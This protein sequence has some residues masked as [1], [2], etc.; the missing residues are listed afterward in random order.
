MT[1]FK[2]VIVPIVTPFSDQDEV[3]VAALHENVEFLISEG[4]HAIL[5]A[6]STGEAMCLTPS[7]Y[8][9]VLE[10]TIKQVRGR[11]PVIAGCSANAT[12]VVVANCELAKELGADGY[13]VTHPYYSRPDPHEL[14]EHY[15]TV[16]AAL[17]RPLIVYNNPYTTGVDASAEQLA[18]FG[19][20]P[21]IEYVKESSGDAT[22]VARLLLLTD[23][24]LHV[25]C[26]TDNLALESFV[27]GATG[28]VAGVAN[29]LPRA[30]VRLYQL[31][32]E[33]NRYVEARDL[34]ASMF[35]F[36]DLAESTGKFVQVNK[37]A[38]E[39]AGHRAGRPR[40]PLLPLDHNTMDALRAAFI[41]ASTAAAG[42]QE[43]GALGS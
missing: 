13:M 1:V 20:L 16:A 35:A 21:H 40:Q 29:S 9:L 24:R 34:Y 19:T 30:C 10:E 36:L 26:G 8:R 28:W 7:E 6:G 39:L 31:A 37:A 42:K 5:P 15:R 41:R 18:A 2:G 3:D 23:G 25:L 38:V 11:V 14:L 33:E 32:A 43:A 22:R 27:A 17:D 4:V 12:R